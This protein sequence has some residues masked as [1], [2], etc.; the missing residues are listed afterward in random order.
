[1]DGASIGRLDDDAGR[2]LETRTAK[3]GDRENVRWR[4]SLF[5]LSRGEQRKK[6]REKIG[7]AIADAEDRHDLRVPRDFSSVAI[8]AVRIRNEE[9]LNI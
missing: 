4:A 9:F 2:T 3:R 6:F 5:D 1:L 8:C 7:R